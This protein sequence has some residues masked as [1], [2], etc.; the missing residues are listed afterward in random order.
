MEVRFLRD[1]DV[2]SNRRGERN[3]PVPRVQEL[4]RRQWRGLLQQRTL[5]A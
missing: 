1:P 5:R 2:L 4:V 3:L